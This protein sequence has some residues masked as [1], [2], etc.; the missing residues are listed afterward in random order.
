[1]L[2]DIAVIEF[3]EGTNLNITPVTLVS[4]YV[5]K[6]GDKAITAGYGIYKWNYDLMSET[7][8]PERP[9]VLQNA[10]VP[11]HVNA[12][13]KSTVIATANLE[14]H[15][16]HGDSGGPL[17]I[18]RN[19]KIYQ[20]GV[21]SQSYNPHPGILINLA[22][23]LSLQCDW[24]TKVTKYEIKCEKLP[25]DLNTKPPVNPVT[26]NPQPGSKKTNKPTT[27][28]TSNVN[29]STTLLPGTPQALKKPAENSSKR[30]AFNI[31]LFLFI[32]ILF[33]A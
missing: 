13:V 18:E 9:E 12:P 5:E 6:E 23:R 19:G 3:P 32:G 15:S 29:G 11:V 21:A 27:K 8:I 20:I 1:M 7:F 31:L 4:D 2:D 22:T 16:D 25:D 17:M 28:R 24:I 26:S 33:F 14:K 10:T 30:F